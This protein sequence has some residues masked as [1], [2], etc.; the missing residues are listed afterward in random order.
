MPPFPDLKTV[1]WTGP[2]RIPATIP[3]LYQAVPDIQHHI[4]KQ[5]T[6]GSSPILL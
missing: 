6:R 1:K 2:L 4:K 3:L 5:N